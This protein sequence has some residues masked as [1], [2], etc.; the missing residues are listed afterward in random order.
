M[1]AT[2]V[3]ASTWGDR[4]GRMDDGQGVL[5]MRMLERIIDL[6]TQ[7]AADHASIVTITARLGLINALLHLW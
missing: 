5:M 3:D 1:A 6:E 4:D 7:A 2:A